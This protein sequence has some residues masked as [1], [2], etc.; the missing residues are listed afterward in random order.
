MLIKKRGLVIKILIAIAIILV[1]IFALYV[2]SDVGVFSVTSQNVS[3]CNIQGYIFGVNGIAIENSTNVTCTLARNNGINTTYNTTTGSSFPNGFNHSYRCTMTCSNVIADSVTIF[4]NNATN[5]GTAITTISSSTTNLNLTFSDTIAPTITG[6]TSNVSVNLAESLTIQINVTDNGIINGGNITLNNGSIL[7]LNYDSGETYQTTIGIPSNNTSSINYYAVVYDNSG[8][9][10]TSATYTI[11]ITDNVNPVASTAVNQ[12]SVGQNIAIQFNGSGS[13]DNVGI[14]NYSWNFGDDTINTSEI[15][16]HQFS[17][18]GTYNVV[19]TIYDQE[20]NSDTDTIIITVSD[21]TTPFVTLNNPSNGSVNITETIIINATFNENIQISGLNNNNVLLKDSNN[22]QIY[23]NISFNSN[24]NISSITPY[25]VL[26]ENTFYTLT[27]NNNLQDSTGNN[28]TTYVFNFTTKAKDSDNDGIPDSIE[29]DDDNDGILDE[30][31]KLIGDSSNIKSTFSSL[32]INVN[33]STNISQVFNAIN[34]LEIQYDSKPIVKYIVDFS[35][36][37]VDLSNISIYETDNSSVG[38]ILI[39]GLDLNGQTKTVYLERKSSYDSV[40]I[41]DTIVTDIAQ[42]SQ[43]CTGSNEYKVY[44]NGTT[45]NEY[46]CTL[47][48]SIG[49]YEI[50]GVSN[51]GVRE[52]DYTPN[53]GGDDDS[54]GGSAGGGGGGGGGLEGCTSQWECG[55]WSECSQNGRK[56]R[57]CSDSNSCSP[58]T[59]TPLMSLYC[60]YVSTEVSSDEENEGIGNDIPTSGDDDDDEIE[61]GI[62]DDDLEEGNTIGGT[63]LS[64]QPKEN[65]EGTGIQITEEEIEKDIAGKAFTVIKSNKANVY[66]LAFIIFIVLSMAGFHIIHEKKQEKSK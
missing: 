64:I 38:E 63:E 49:K 8:N 48:S 43:A 47:N 13:T 37:I 54:S 60:V 23:S 53:S 21:S 19:L 6:I 41:K 29:T 10:V 26:N 50:T 45:Y 34:N 33:G 1:S 36:T 57:T 18:P 35:A 5:N 31:D 3:L 17:S 7:E 59:G 44:C 40:C 46:T 12:T 16:L 42:I 30:S 27:F 20:G 9:N 62:S 14:I 58:S 51:T 4:S 28:L 15:P 61:Q 52:I 39:N 56:T 11:N 24:T 66:F 22:N 25:I 2:N 32:S 65:Q 55:S